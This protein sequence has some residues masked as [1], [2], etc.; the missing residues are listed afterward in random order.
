MRFF[1]SLLYAEQT[2]IKAVVPDF[3]LSRHILLSYGKT[4]S[5]DRALIISLPLPPF[6]SVAI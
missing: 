1:V 2:G 6:H 3:L 5:D 4:D